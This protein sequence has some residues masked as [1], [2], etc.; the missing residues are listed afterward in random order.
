MSLTE[1]QRQMLATS[2]AGGPHPVRP[3]GPGQWRMAGKLAELG[4]GTIIGDDAFIVN[5]AGLAELERHD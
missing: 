1:A 5:S 2:A 4:L 3:I